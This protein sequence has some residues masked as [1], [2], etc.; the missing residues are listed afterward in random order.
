MAPFET[1]WKAPTASKQAAG[2]SGE[3]SPAPRRASPEPRCPRCGTT[4]PGPAG[5]GPLARQSLTMLVSFSWEPALTILWDPKLSCFPCRGQ[6]QHT[7][8]G[9][10]GKAAP[11][12]DTWTDTVT[13]TQTHVADGGQAAWLQG[14]E[15]CKTQKAGPLLPEAKR[16]WIF[17]FVLKRCG[18]HSD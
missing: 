12:T 14:A 2:C 7:A 15:S 8:V 18:L 6:P 1:L 10:A 17:M 3:S 4:S 5:P 11:S 16:F 13:A 9:A